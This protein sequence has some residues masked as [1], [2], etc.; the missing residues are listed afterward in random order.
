[1]QDVTQDDI[2]KKLDESPLQSNAKSV[3]GGVLVNTEDFDD[4]GMTLMYQLVRGVKPVVREGGERFLLVFL[5]LN[6]SKNLDKRKKVC[7]SECWCL[8]FV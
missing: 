2:L 4:Y 6:K 7:T 1:M 3:H 8:L 5:V